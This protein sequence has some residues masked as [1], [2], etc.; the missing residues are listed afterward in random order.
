[1]HK[2]PHSNLVRF[3]RTMKKILLLFAVL[4]IIG[5]AFWRISIASG[6]R[7][8]KQCRVIM[9]TYVTI[10]AYG[11]KRTVSRAIDHAFERMQKVAKR[12]N[13]HDQASPIYAFNQ[14]GTP[15]RDTEII[16]LVRVALE[17][18]RASEG[19]FDITVYPLV[20]LWGFY[21]DLPQEVAAPEKIKEILGNVGYKHLMISDTELKS[22]QENIAIDLGGIAKGYVV[23]QG[24]DALKK[25][26]ISS[27][28]I[29]AGGDVY[30]LGEKNSK[31]WNVGIR[32]PRGK[33]LL[34][35][36]Q[37]KD[38]AVMGS[39]DYE[40]YY[41]REGKRFHHIIDP[42]TGC[43]STG[44]S[45]VTVIYAD[46][47][48]ADAWGTALSVL[49]PEKGLKVIET[50]PGLEAIV[51]TNEGKVFYSAGLKQ[52]LKTVSRKP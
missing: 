5:I 42:K 18:S 20:K 37:V 13:A 23:G 46:P 30:A 40:R 34:G 44:V 29:Q 6:A 3:R 28:I 50:I 33:G 19:A 17:I 2:M 36:L 8:E 16:N 9:D 41:V 51:V 25:E 7:L 52:A 48:I 35:Y 38:T 47:A 12:F 45:G 10:Y 1:M 24:V 14:K 31:P 26:G 49:G 22:D 27:A 43:P 21:E 32:D 11:P 15:I 4:A 39:G